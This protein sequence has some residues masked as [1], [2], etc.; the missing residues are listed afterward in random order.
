M[1][2]CRLQCLVVLGSIKKCID[3]KMLDCR[4]VVGSV[5]KQKGEEEAEKRKI[6]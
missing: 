6:F 2:D 5:K 1:L 3:S 4:L